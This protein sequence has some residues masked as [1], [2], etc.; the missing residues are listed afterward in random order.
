MPAIAHD[1]HHL[2]T[3]TIPSVLV[4]REWGHGHPGRRLSHQDRNVRSWDGI[5]GHG[6]ACIDLQSSFCP[7]NMSR[8][9]PQTHNGDVRP[10]LCTV[11]LFGLV[12]FFGAWC[13][14]VLLYHT[15]FTCRKLVERWL[16]WPY[17]FFPHLCRPMS[18]NSQMCTDLCNEGFKYCILTVISDLLTVWQ[19]PALTFTVT[20][21]TT[22]FW[23]CP[24][25]PH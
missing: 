22:A 9:V 10:P 5:K 1:L 12:L 17:H 20:W 7:R 6:I 3:Q 24:Y 25:V 15:V 23:C 4:H 19:R 11:Q 21:R 13:T 16:I 2:H 14:C 18:L 8:K